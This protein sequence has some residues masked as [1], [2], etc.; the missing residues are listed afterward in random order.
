MITDK[1]DLDVL[2]VLP[3]GL[4][5]VSSMDECKY[6]GH[7]SNT[8]VQVTDSPARIAVTVSKKNLTCDCASGKRFSPAGCA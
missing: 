2:L 3:S 5:I 8:G 4:Y 1:V 7:I 6:N